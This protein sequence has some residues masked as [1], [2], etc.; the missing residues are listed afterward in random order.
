M[1]TSDGQTARQV[2]GKAHQRVDRPESGARGPFLGG[3]DCSGG[4]R[5]AVGAG[6]FVTNLFC[7]PQ[8]GGCGVFTPAQF[9]SGDY[10][11]SF[12]C[13]SCG[14]TS[15]IEVRLPRS[16]VHA[17][18]DESVFKDVI[19]YGLVVVPDPNVT[20]AENLLSEL[21]QR[22]GVD[23]QEEFHCKHAFHGDRRRKTQWKHLSEV[24]VLNFAEELISGLVTLPAWFIVGAALRSEIPVEF[25]AAQGFSAG[26]MESKQ[27]A[28]ILCGAALTPLS[29]HYDQDEIRFWADR[30]RTRVPFFGRKMQAHTNYKLTNREANRHIVSETFDKNNKPA[31][32]QV[33]DLLAYVA[34]HALSEKKSRHKERFEHLYRTFDPVT[35]FLVYH[36]DQVGPENRRPSVLRL[37]HAKIS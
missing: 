28:G 3:F 34:T 2:K 20:P 15:T 9:S 10:D 35:C 8:R 33:A 1:N 5:L 16:G 26:V 12:T 14:D 27:L 6:L 17:F 4:E 29:E 22:Y 11:A 30:D 21:K 23:P 19:A 32:L 25:P 37:R 13:P 24:K 18:G 36:P 31:L 7:H